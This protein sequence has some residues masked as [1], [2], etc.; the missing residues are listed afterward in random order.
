VALQPEVILSN[1]TPVT[2]ALQR[3]TNTIP[4]VFVVVSDPVGSK[5]VTNIA[6]P[7]ANITGFMNVEPF[8]VEKWLELLMEL[9]PSPT[10]VAVMFNPK[11]APY[12]KFYLQHLESAA[13]KLGVKTV[14]LPIRSEN[15]INEAIALLGQE[16]GSG[17][18]AMTDAY[19]TVHRKLVIQAT[20]QHKVPLMYFFSN[21]PREGGLISYGVDIAEIFRSAAPYVD[22][23]LRGAKPADLPVQTPTKYE[24]VVNLKTAKALGLTIPTSILL[25]ADQIIE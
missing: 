2:A 5:F 17:L 21:V 3:T 15:E 14:P 22:E 25:R 8:L 9:A 23:I 12:A 18:I 4:I 19:M 6:R 16:Q 24:L 1:T 11:T 13:S 10:R 7:E 20:M